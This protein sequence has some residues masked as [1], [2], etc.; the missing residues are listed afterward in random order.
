MMGERLVPEVRL[1]ELTKSECFALLAHEYLGRVAVVD[2]RGPVVFPVNF[3]L[4]RHMVVFCT[5]EGTKLD[6]ASRGS[7][8]AFEIDGTDTVAHTGWSVL[9]RGE[10]IEVTDPTELARMR[11][12][13]LSP[14][15]PGA[16]THYVRILP[17]V[18]TG[19]RIWAP[20]G[21]SHRGSEPSAGATGRPRQ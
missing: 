21:V 3:V 7:K 12:L 19:R 10:A 18:L 16:I 6:A 1:Q 17:A 5:A 8:V 11:K 13:P 2:D 20:S 14:W 4:D 15:A 9:V